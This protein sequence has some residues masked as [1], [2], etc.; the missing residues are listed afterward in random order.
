MDGCPQE[1][2]ILLWFIDFDDCAEYDV[3]H[4]FDNRSGGA[5]SNVMTHSIQHFPH[6]PHHQLDHLGHPGHHHH[7]DGIPACALEVWLRVYAPTGFIARLEAEPFPG[8]GARSKQS[9]W[10]TTSAP[11]DIT[12]HHMVLLFGLEPSVR[13]S[14]WEGRG[15]SSWRSRGRVRTFGLASLCWGIGWW[16]SFGGAVQGQGAL[17]RPRLHQIWCSAGGTSQPAPPLPPPDIQPDDAALQEIDW[18]GISHKQQIWCSWTVQHTKNL[19]IYCGGSQLSLH[20][21]LLLLLVY[22]DQDERF[23]LCSTRSGGWLYQTWCYIQAAPGLVQKHQTTL[24]TAGE[25]AYPP[26]E[27]C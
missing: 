12:S 14:D 26:P 8:S 21:S 2:P 19:V 27:R 6:R 25:R 18:E 5:E 9:Q 7:H 23:I 10:R 17:V 11:R 20:N 22:G 3:E 15:G 16:G 1:G 24:F 4:G 13:G